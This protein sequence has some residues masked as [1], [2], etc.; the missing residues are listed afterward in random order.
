[1]ERDVSL[2]DDFG[3]SRINDGRGKACLLTT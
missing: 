3:G 2:D 1:M